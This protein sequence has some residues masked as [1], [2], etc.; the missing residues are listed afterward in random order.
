MHDI[1]AF[2]KERGIILFSDEVYRPLYHSLPEGTEPPPPAT[3]LGYEKTLVTGS[4]SKVY[5]LAGIRVGWVA[6]WDRSI[7]DTIVDTRD[8]TTIS[9]SQVDDQI[10]SFALSPAVQPSLLARN[11]ERAQQN[12]QILKAWMKKH[13]AT[14]SWVEPQGGT[15]AFVCLRKQGQPVVDTK[16]CLDLMKETKVLVAPGSHCFGGDTDFAGYVRVGYV[17]PTSVLEEGLKRLGEYIERHLL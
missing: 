5:S 8:Y 12:L 13:E 6:S 11:T 9:V 4:M 7:I 3:A 16:F 15:T 14:C 2:A 10:A 1:A 17:C